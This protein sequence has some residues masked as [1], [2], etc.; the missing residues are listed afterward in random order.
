MATLVFSSLLKAKFS[1]SLQ[2]TL[3]WSEQQLLEYKI[4]SEHYHTCTEND[5]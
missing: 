4:C 5:S 3:H 2:I 1:V